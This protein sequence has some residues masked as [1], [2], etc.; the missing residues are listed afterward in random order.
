MLLVGEEIENELILLEPGKAWWFY[1][2]LPWK[3]CLL[4]YNMKT[5][6]QITVQCSWSATQGNNVLLTQVSKLLVMLKS[7]K[8]LR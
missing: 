2:V 6:Q 7:L 4:I 3:D 5:G 1:S 8:F